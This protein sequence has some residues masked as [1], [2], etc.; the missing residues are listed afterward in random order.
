MFP[1]L[2]L[3]TACESLLQIMMYYKCDWGLF[4][5]S[6]RVLFIDFKDKERYICE[7]FV[8]VTFVT[9]K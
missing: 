7:I 6:G 3:I 5:V 4:H 1:K 2:K 9:L 8:K